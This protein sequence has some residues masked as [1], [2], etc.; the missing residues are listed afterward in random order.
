MNRITKRTKST[1]QSWH[2]GSGGGRVDDAVCK[3]VDPVQVEVVVV[4][5]EDV[6][7]SVQ[8][9]HEFVLPLLVIE[10]E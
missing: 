5:R 2:S 8:V 3:Q 10:Q 7:Q 4:F 6:G 9:P 1:N